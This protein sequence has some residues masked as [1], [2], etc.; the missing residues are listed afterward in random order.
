[1]RKQNLEFKFTE[2]EH[3]Y[4]NNE[5][6]DTSL[7]VDIKSSNEEPFSLSPAFESEV[8]RYCWVPKNNS[9]VLNLDFIVKKDTQIFF[10]NELSISNNFKIFAKEGPKEYKFVFQKSRGVFLFR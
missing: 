10:N 7:L 1:M 5:K 9:D 4:N 3:V 2:L 8:E 6:N